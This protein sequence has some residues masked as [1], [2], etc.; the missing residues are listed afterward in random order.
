MD[1]N[2][3]CHTANANDEAVSEMQIDIEESEQQD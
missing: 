2:Q 1:E 3:P